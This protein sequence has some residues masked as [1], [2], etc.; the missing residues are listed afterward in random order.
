MCLTKC[1]RIIFVALLPVKLKAS[2]AWSSK[3]KSGWEQPARHSSR[4]RDGDHGNLIVINC[5]MGPSRA[6]NRR[7]G[8]RLVMATFWPGGMVG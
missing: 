8:L 7:D 2:S 4:S 3:L 6:S 1:V 5:T